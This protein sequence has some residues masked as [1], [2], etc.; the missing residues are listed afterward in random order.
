MWRSKRLGNT[1]AQSKARRAPSVRSS[2][3]TCRIF[4]CSDARTC[5]AVVADTGAN[6]L[7][8]IYDDG[9]LDAHGVWP[10]ERQQL[11]LDLAQKLFR[12]PQESGAP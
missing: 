3:P 10:L 8:E 4:G 12:A 11:R 6:Y 1:R 2:P 9:W 5:V 7:D